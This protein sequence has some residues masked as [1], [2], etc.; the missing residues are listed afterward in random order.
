MWVSVEVTSNGAGSYK[1][2]TLSFT[3]TSSVTPYK[4]TPLP[5]PG[6]SSGSWTKNQSN[7][8]FTVGVT[9]SSNTLG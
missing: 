6:S 9:Y 5:P 3:A 7:I 4:V 2:N 1:V 8:P